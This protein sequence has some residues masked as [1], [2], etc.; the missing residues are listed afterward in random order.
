MKAFYKVLYILLIF[1]IS[2]LKPILAAQK[3]T[4]DE[5]SIA[6]V[7]LYRNEVETI[8]KK[9]GVV[10]EIWL[11]KQGKE[12]PKASIKRQS[13]TGFFI[14]KGKSMFLVTASH[15]AKVLTPADKAVLRYRKDKPISLSLNILSGSKK[16]LQWSFHK[17]ADIAVLTLHPTQEVY[18][19]YLT[20]RFLPFEILIQEEKSSEREIPL[21]VIGFPRGLGVKDH[22]SPLTLQ[23]YS[24]SGLLKMRR[25]D[26]YQM[27]TFFLLQDPSI[28]GY[29]GAP[30]FDLGYYKLGSM[31]STSGKGTLCYGLI[32]GTIS[33]DTGGKLAAVIPSTFIVELITQVEELEKWIKKIDFCSEK[34]LYPKKEYYPLEN[35]KK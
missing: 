28:G 24:S 23:S 26:T 6:V 19:K 21:T 35:N 14:A 11:R 15:V 18:T 7:F 29:S 30:V 33:D 17:K 4:I 2:S 3:F 12:K 27:A 5:L 31:T 22:F 13:G 25:F 16:K 1:F 9:D 10:Y 34:E 20:N 8:K 32:H